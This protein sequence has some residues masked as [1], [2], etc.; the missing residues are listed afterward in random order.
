MFRG[1]VTSGKESM[2]ANG[3]DAEGLFETRTMKVEAMI[4]EGTEG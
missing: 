4:A 3:Y 1:R 2:G